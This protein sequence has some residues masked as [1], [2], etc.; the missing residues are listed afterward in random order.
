[1]LGGNKHLPVVKPRRLPQHISY[2]VERLALKNRELSGAN[3]R[4]T[5]FYC[6]SQLPYQSDKA[7]GTQRCKWSQCP[8][9]QTKMSKLYVSPPR[10]RFPV[11]AA[12]T[13]PFRFHGMAGNRL[14]PHTV[15]KGGKTQR[16][17]W[18]FTKPIIRIIVEKSKEIDKF[19]RMRRDLQSDMK[20]A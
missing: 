6:V 4:L 13:P 20:K 8:Q 16:G 7:R 19:R 3:R 17:R 5:S 15:Y 9:S 1:M 2:L 12:H 10:N 14:L 11:K 18:D